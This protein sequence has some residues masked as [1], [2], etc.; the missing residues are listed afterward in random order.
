MH[1]NNDFAAAAAAA[2]SAQAK[3][4]NNRYNK[5]DTPSTA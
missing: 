1:Q 2:T 5:T 3:M 4:K